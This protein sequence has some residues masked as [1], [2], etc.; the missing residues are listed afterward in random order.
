VDGQPI[1]VKLHRPQGKHSVLIEQAKVDVWVSVG[2]PPQPADEPA[3]LLTAR[4]GRLGC[5]SEGVLDGQGVG[6]KREGGVDAGLD[7][8]ERQAGR[9]ASRHRCDREGGACY[10]GLAKVVHE[11]N[12]FGHGFDAVGGT[13]LVSEAHALSVL[14]GACWCE[15]PNHGGMYLMKGQVVRS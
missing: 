14:V 13:S 12:V 15:T 1:I 8:G 10:C 2:S 3:L 4:R 5:G 11:G 7:R 9:V 6:Q